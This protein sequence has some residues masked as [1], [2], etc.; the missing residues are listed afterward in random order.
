MSSS[1]IKVN[2][3]SRAT[4]LKIWNVLVKPYI[5]QYFF[6]VRSM[7]NAKI[8]LFVE[9]C[10]LTIAIR[11]LI[12]T[13]HYVVGPH[14]SEYIPLTISPWILTLHEN[15]FGTWGE[16]LLV[17]F[18]WDCVTVPPPSP[19]PPHLGYTTV[20]YILFMWSSST[21]CLHWWIIK[22]SH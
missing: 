2:V 13:I 9:Y 18:C 15:S 6:K 22:L 12:L 16:F 8:L 20:L 10:I 1:T 5:N 14:C 4:K 11:Q 21:H 3:L 17:S 19:P 7:S